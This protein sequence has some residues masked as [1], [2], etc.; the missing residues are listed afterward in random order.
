VEFVVGAPHSWGGG[1]A[2]TLI[3][4]STGRGKRA[5]QPGA[6]GKRACW[7]GS[8]PGSPANGLAGVEATGEALEQNQECRLRFQTNRIRLK[9]RAQRSV[10]CARPFGLR[11]SCPDELGIQSDL[12]ILADQ[13]AACFESRIPVQGE[14]LAVDSAGGGEPDTGVAPGVLCR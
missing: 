8:N 7:G 2:S 14:I 5:E 3:A 13:D 11:N 12:Y 10:C 4:R 6:P 9:G 1:S